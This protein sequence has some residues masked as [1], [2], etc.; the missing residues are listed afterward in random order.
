MLHC[1]GIRVSYSQKQK[2]VLIVKFSIVIPLIHA[3]DSNILKKNA[4]QQGSVLFK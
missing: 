4:K 3:N 1:L 2:W